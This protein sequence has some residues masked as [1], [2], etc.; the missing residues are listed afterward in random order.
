MSILVINPGS[1]STKLALFENSLPVGEP[2]ALAEVQHLRE[3]LAPFERVADQFD[4]R[5]RDVTAFLDREGVDTG[6]IEALSVRGGLLR[7]L[8]GGVYEVSDEMVHDLANA[9][10][11]EHACNLGGMLGLAL[12]RKWG[13]PAFV[14]DPVV[15]DELMDEARLTGM[16]GLNRRSLFHA[17]NQRGTA[18]LVARRLGIEYEDANFIVCHIGGGISIGAHRHGRV[19]DVI[20]ALDGEGPFSPER[21]GSLP[22]VP[23]LDM[24]A[25]GERTPAELKETILRHGGLIAHLGTNDLREVLARVEDGD[26]RAELVYRSM[27]YNIARCIA[28]MGPALAGDQGGLDLAAVVLTG[29]LARSRTLVDDLTRR[30]SWLAPI[31]VIP[32]EAEMAALAGGAIRVLSGRLPLQAY[33]ID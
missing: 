32:G 26:E 13:A 23:V 19:V 28:S 6:D 31:E 21:T 12:S 3:E 24:I 2:L 10:Y 30:L 15:T 18:R 8:P 5:L 1:T 14:V 33:V 27:G 7:A 9:T 17:L 4:L 20:N 29:G 16:P 22:L 11:G 25:R